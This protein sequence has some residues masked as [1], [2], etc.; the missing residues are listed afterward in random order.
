MF[1][2][3]MKF[4]IT[5]TKLFTYLVPSVLLETVNEYCAGSNP[6]TYFLNSAMIGIGTGREL[7]LFLVFWLLVAT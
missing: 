3:I 2:Q 1:P 4:E 6:E 5:Q 7:M